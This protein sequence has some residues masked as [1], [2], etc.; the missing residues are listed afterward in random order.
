MSGP[1]TSGPGDLSLVG[2]CALVTGAGGAIGAAVTS[3]LLTAGAAVH[4]LDREACPPPAG[5][6][7]LPC[8]LR[9]PAAIRAA[10]AATR[11]DGVRFDTFVH[12]AGIT[13][14]GVLWKLDATAWAEVIAVNLTS[15]FHLLAAL[16]PDLRASGGGAVVLIASINGERGKFGQANY[17]ASKAG[18]IGLAKSAAREFG[19][20][21]VR[22]NVVSP[23]WIETPMTADLPA[24]ARTTALAECALPRLGTA[25]DVAGVVHF[26]CSS[27]SAH[28]TG[29]VL[30]V[31]GGQCTA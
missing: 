25:E 9:D 3:R 30:R 7:H 21:A 28:V 14:D 16:A 18:L 12:C 1:A 10:L 13:R 8:D 19:R 31:D 23:G 4:G 15:A 20:S 29:Q 24:D 5:A 27:L 2:R 22:V 6:Q 11:A 26:L 17:A